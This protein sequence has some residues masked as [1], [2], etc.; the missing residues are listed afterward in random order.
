MSLEACQEFP[1]NSNTTNEL[2]LEYSQ[3]PVKTNSWK[4]ELGMH[5]R[6][7]LTSFEN[8]LTKHS[9]LLLNWP[10]WETNRVPMAEIKLGLYNWMT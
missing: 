2:E 5:D 3:F 7:W 8:N 4:L 1:I 10:E 6:T 9:K